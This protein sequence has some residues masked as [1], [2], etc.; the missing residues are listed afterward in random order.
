MVLII[1]NRHTLL[2]RQGVVA[3]CRRL[4]WRTT[5]IEFN[6]IYFRHQASSSHARQKAQDRQDLRGFDEKT[7]LSDGS[8]FNIA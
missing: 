4:V 5:L 6:V 2:R 3:I 7:T 8:H 1:P